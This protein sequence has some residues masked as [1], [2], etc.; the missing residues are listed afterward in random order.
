MKNKET[1]DAVLKAMREICRQRGL[2]CATTEEIVAHTG[3]SKR[4]VVAAIAA[5]RRKRA[6]N[7]DKVFE[8]TYADADAGP[9]A[10]AH[11][12]TLEELWGDGGG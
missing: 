6:S 3:L 1:A 5:L 2:C 9:T 10:I 12:W 7:A 11:G 4:V 8:T